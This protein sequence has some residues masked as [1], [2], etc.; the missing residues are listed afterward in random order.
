MTKTHLNSGT[1]N[2]RVW[3]LPV[4]LFHWL[5]VVMCGISWITAEMGGNAME[6]H[7]WSGYV[8]LGLVLFR[9]LWGIWGSETARFSHFIHGPI[10]VL[11]YTRSLLKPNYK[12]AMGHNPLGGWSVISLLLILA[13][14][15]ISGLFAND[16]IANEGPL[17]HLVRK[18]TSNFLSQ[19]HQYSFNILLGLV[20][21]HLA[22]IIFY[23]VKHRVNLLKP[24]LTGDKL[25]D[26][27]AAETKQTHLLV[28]IVL[29]LVA[30]AT[31]Y[32]VVM[33]L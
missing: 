13:I 16:D 11:S 2:M 14:Q 18:A 12:A 20:I 8:V 27:N 5:L 15:A 7:M 25:V 21:L 17:Y 19:V 4:R 28:A 33:K 32:W 22:A 31:V 26:I 1:K 30:A 6:W 29:I 23:H 24:M 9:I 10:T 3:D